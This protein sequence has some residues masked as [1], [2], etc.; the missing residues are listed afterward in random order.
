LTAEPYAIANNL[1]YQLTASVPVFRPDQN[2][3]NL[4]TL[5][6]NYFFTSNGPNFSNKTILLAW[7]R[8]HIPPTVNALIASYGL[9]PLSLTWSGTDYDSIWTIRLD[10]HGNLSADNAL[11]EGINSD[12][13][14]S[15]PPQF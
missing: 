3:P 10:A 7:E 9:A 15:T 8:D 2:A 6:S 13:L 14:P 1:P 12:L 11:C 5:A 4:A